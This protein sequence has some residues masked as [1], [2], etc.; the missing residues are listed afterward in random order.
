MKYYALL[1]NIYHFFLLFTCLT[2]RV[3]AFPW[4]ETKTYSVLHFFELI[5]HEWNWK[6]SHEYIIDSSAKL[7]G[8]ISHNDL[9]ENATHAY[10][11]CIKALEL[12]AMFCLKQCHLRIEWYVFVYWSVNG[13]YSLTGRLMVCTR[14][15]VG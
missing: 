4:I 5:T 7:V 3:F 14:L 10:A 15:L 2:I 13:M 8:L 9:T 11:C 6:Q 1:S 12:L